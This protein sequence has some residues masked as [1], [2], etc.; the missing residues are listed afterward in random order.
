LTASWI[1]RVRLLVRTTIGG[2]APDRAQLGDGDLEVGQHLEQE[3]LEG[4]VGAVELVDQQH[5]RHGAPGRWP[6]AARADQ[7]AFAEELG[8]QG[9]AVTPSPRPGGSPSSARP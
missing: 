4:L 2:C 6:A 1:S 3:G 8:G 9:V 5:R 7:E